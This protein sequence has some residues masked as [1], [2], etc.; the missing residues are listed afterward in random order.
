MKPSLEGVDLKLARA[1]EHLAFLGAERAA[2]LEA[3]RDAVVREFDPQRGDHVFRIAGQ[4][5]PLAWGVVVG[6]F[7]H[8]LRSSLDNTIW[9]LILQRGRHPTDRVQFPI[10]KDKANFEGQTNKWGLPRLVDPPDLAFVESAQPYHA[11]GDGPVDKTA[12]KWHPLSMLSH[13]NNVDKHRTIHPAC[14]AARIVRVDPD[15]TRRA[16]FI[17]SD[18]WKLAAAQGR[19]A[20]MGLPV[21]FYRDG[22]RM[23]GGFTFAGSDDDPAEIIRVHATGGS[24][25]QVDVQTRPTIDVA[26]SDWELPMDIADLRDIRDTVVQIVEHFRPAF[27]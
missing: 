17:R 9:Q 3:N 2:L 12:I 26:F 7:A 25:A 6:E 24:G 1:N 13:L 27:G 11:R 16:D 14:G 23:C 5:P 18:R 15:G 8:A 22:T 21:P 10:Y 20:A 19:V 4:R